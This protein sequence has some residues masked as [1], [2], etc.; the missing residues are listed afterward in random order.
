MGDGNPWPRIG[1]FVFL[2]FLEAL[3]SAAKTALGQLSEQQVEKDLE[4]EDEKKRRKAA[5]VKYLL[6]IEDWYY[7]TAQFLKVSINIVIGVLVSSG[8][9]VYAGNMA[10]RLHLPGYPVVFG[11][12]FLVIFT[13]LLLFSVVLI[14]NVVPVKLAQIHSENVAYAFSGM[15]LFWITVLKPFMF[16]IDAATR[17]I[18]KIMRIKPEDLL[19]NVTEDEIISIVNEGFE[20]GVLEDNEVEMISNIIELD[21][22]EV[23]DVM[24]NRRKVVSVSTDLSVEEALKFMLGASYSRFPLY[25]GERDN[26][27]GVLHFKDVTQHYMAGDGLSLKEIARE[28]FFVPD[29]QGVDKL[30]DAM[31]FNKIH[32]AI[33]VDEYGQMAGVVALEDILEEIVGNIL[34][35]YDVDERMIL[36]QGNHRY[37]IRGLTPID[38]IEDELG[39]SFDREDYDFDTLNGF[40]TTM[41]GHLPSDQ[42]KSIVRY[43][44]YRFQILD[45]KN[46]MIRSVRVVRENESEM[47]AKRER[48][49]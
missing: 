9:L 36:K 22:K 3:V 26:I 28:P 49:N 41:L 7:D 21:D 10:K 35:E 39:I 34:D 44:G 6:S 42:E 20:Q 47:E 43:Q 16:L 4:S 1:A 8:L 37:I 14:G 33:A 2:V 45:A 30:F 25:E 31:Q 19:D 11:I 12:V 38:E 23:R 18:L 5:R 15:M 29:T 17:L 46:K 48:G 27:V 13:A 40:L 24:T 32:M